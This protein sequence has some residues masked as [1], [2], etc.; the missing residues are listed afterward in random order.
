MRTSCEPVLRLL[1]GPSSQPL[2]CCRY[3]KQ[4]PAGAAKGEAAPAPAPAPSAAAAT[5]AAGGGAKHYLSTRRCVIR[6]GFDMDSAKAGT[7]EKGVVITVLE[8]RI[9]DK[10][11]VRVHFKAD[12]EGNPLEGWTSQKTGTGAVVLEPAPH[13][14]A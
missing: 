4:I 13:R 14:A 1:V 2:L 5:P 10:G 12:F 3:T 8:E 11:V 6:S 9:N 7:L